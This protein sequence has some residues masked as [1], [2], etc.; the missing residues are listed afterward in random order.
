M[1]RRQLCVLSDSL[2]C[3]PQKT[4]EIFTGFTGSQKEVS[5][6]IAGPAKAKKAITG[7]VNSVSPVVLNV[8]EIKK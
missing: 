6:E 2:V 3:L 7:A 4:N 5:S 8:T 1:R